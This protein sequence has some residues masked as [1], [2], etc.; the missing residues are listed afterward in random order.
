[1]WSTFT[2]GLQMVQERLMEGEEEGEQHGQ[3]RSRELIYV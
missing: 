3:V 1:M 2:A